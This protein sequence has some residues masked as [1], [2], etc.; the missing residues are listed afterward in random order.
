MKKIEAKPKEENANNDTTKSTNEENVNST[1]QIT[2]KKDEEPNKPEGNQEKV[3]NTN[4]QQEENTEDKSKQE[5]TE[6]KNK[7]E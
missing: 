1:K 3:E 4:N 7:E 6:Q 2:Q 5:S